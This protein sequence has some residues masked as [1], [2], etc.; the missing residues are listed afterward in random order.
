MTLV[1]AAPEGLAPYLHLLSAPSS[2]Q[3]I[4]LIKS[5]FQEALV[6][7]QAITSPLVPDLWLKKKKKKTRFQIS[8][9]DLYPNKVF[10]ESLLS[11]DE[12]VTSTHEY[13]LRGFKGRG[14]RAWRLLKA[15]TFINA[16]KK[17]SPVART[18]SS[19]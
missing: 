15:S 1:R 2:R 12:N 16:G 9:P 5:N 4:T 11:R 3:Q 17:N 13:A 8:Y 7:P 18:T 14:Q 19:N 6:L 10:R